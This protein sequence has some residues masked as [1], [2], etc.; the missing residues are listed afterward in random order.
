[1]SGYQADLGQTYWGNLYDESR[2]NKILVQANQAELKKVLKPNDWN[3][4]RIRCQ[5]RQIQLWINGHL[6][7]NYTETE[8]QMDPAG[9]IG[10]QIHGGP[11]SEAWYK[12][13]KIK[14]LP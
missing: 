4:Y 6:T 10:L 9:I 13:L 7:V 14:S 8:A 2:R 12:D 3:D 11:P 1:V 5:G